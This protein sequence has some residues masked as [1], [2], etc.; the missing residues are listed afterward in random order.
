MPFSDLYTSGKRTIMNKTA[1]IPLI[2]GALL[3]SGCDFRQKLNSANPETKQLAENVFQQLRHH[4]YDS[5]KPQLDSSIDASTVQQN[6]E[7]LST[8]IPDEDPVSVRTITTSKFCTVNRGCMIHL[9]LEYQY[10]SQWMLAD[11]STHEQDG[12]RLISGLHA[13]SEPASLQAQNQ[14]TWS[15]K[16]PLHFIFLGICL[17][18]I[19]FDLWILI[20]CIRT[21]VPGR[22]WL[23]IL[24]IVVGILRVSLNWT[25]GELSYRLLWLSFPIAGSSQSLFDAMYFYFSIPIG[26]IAFLFYEDKWKEDAELAKI[27]ATKAAELATAEAPLP[28]PPSDETH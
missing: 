5:I 12:V 24:F 20:R 21:K 15:G 2:C 26:A 28:E 18:V 8:H 4:Q 7:E 1:W 22:K 25:S 11:I 3:L 16:T 6:L 17:F 10:H 19:L 14:F 27:A 9:V 23:W 13:K